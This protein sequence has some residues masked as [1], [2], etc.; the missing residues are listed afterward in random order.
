MDW[1]DV[2]GD[3]LPD[4]LTNYEWS[5]L[6]RLSF[7]PGLEKVKSV[8]S[9]PSVDIGQI[10]NAESIVLSGFDGD[11][12]VD[13]DEDIADLDSDW[14]TPYDAIKLVWCENPGAG[15]PEQ[16]QP[17]KRHLIYRGQ[18]FY[19]KPQLGV[20]DI[21]G[22]RR[23]D[24]V[25]QP[26]SRQTIYFFRNTGAEN[27]E[28]VRIPKP[29]ETQWRS[30]PTH[31]FDLN[32]DGKQGIIGFLIQDEGYLPKDKAAVY[33]VEYEGKEPRADNWKTHIIKWGD[34]YN[35]RDTYVGE[36]WDQAFFH[37]VD[38][39]GDIDI[40]ANCGEYGTN[41]GPP[42]ALAMLWFENPM[43]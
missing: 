28:L 30:R 32:G 1:A 40:I 10:K 13:G 23:P 31:V 3:R 11:G 39:D 43:K 14:N 25:L 33:W 38:G 26:E 41:D 9:W 21:D 18:E 2:N 37:D 4:Y 5:G 22:D 7:H 35:G 15:K 24:L 27:W 42:A 17:W 20:D 16:R 34:D 19:T 6:V 29:P 36:K 8:D 12:H